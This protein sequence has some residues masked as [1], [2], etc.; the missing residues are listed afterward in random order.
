MNQR[1][2]HKKI[3]FSEHKKFLCYCFDSF[4]ILMKCLFQIGENISRMNQGIV[5][6]QCQVLEL[7]IP[8]THIPLFWLLIFLYH[9][10]I[11]YPHPKI[12]RISDGVMKPV[13]W[14]EVILTQCWPHF[15]LARQLFIISALVF[16]FA[17]FFH[18]FIFSAGHLI[19]CHLFIVGSALLHLH[20]FSS[21]FL[22]HL[23]F[24]V[25]S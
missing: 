14:H 4:I 6:N 18:L 5:A 16:F 13:G 11:C 12:N 22:L 25:S 21:F 7:Q 19:R 3:Y 24:Q 15:Y 1:P 20:W 10:R 17:L 23:A 8:I 2:K 9:I